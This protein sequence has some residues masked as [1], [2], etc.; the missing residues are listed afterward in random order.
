MGGQLHCRPTQPTHIGNEREQRVPPALSDCL[1]KH[2]PNAEK[3]DER[4]PR[5]SKADAWSRTYDLSAGHDIY[6]WLL[7]NDTLEGNVSD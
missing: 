2:D 3:R 6:A 4:H 7:G 1:E 5:I